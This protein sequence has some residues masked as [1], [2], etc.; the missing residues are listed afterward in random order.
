MG[1]CCSGDAAA[2]GNGNRQTA[3]LTRHAQQ[4]ASLFTQDVFI[5]VFD[6]DGNPAWSFGSSPQVTSEFQ[7][8]LHPIHE[9]VSATEQTIRNLN[10]GWRVDELTAFRLTCLSSRIW[11]WV[12]N[13]PYHLV[14]INKLNSGEAFGTDPPDFAERS[15][16][17]SGQILDTLL[18][19]SS[20][21]VD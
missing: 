2:D 7:A 10:E 13:G 20:S 3:T 21:P 6:P 18:R 4:L 15:T 5:V 8:Q 9:A 17:L 19:P 12:I 11:V 14:V 16:A 1:A